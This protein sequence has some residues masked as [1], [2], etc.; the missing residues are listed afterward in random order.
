MANTSHD[1]HHNYPE[2]GH[3]N[4]ISSAIVSGQGL[5]H[6]TYPPSELSVPAQL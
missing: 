1:I 3:I 4:E 2:H 6:K 5:P